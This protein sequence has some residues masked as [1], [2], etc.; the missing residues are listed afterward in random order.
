MADKFVKFYDKYDRAPQPLSE[1]S[2]QTDRVDRVPSWEFR[3]RRKPFTPR[4]W[5]RIP[6]DFAYLCWANPFILNFGHLRR[7]TLLTGLCAAVLAGVLPI[8]VLQ[9]DGFDRDIAS[10]HDC[11]LERVVLRKT[12]PDLERQFRTPWVPFI[13]VA[14]LV[15]G[16]AIDFGY[17]YKYSRL[18]RR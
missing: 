3:N 17:S 15:V 5:Q 9:L 8:D 14:W 18:N 11:L 16:M 6:W 7:L 2:P 13:P 12:R 1:S 4:S 10:L